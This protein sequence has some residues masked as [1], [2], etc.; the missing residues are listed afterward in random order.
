MKSLLLEQIEGSWLLVSMT[1]K[2]DE[3]KEVDLYG[4]SPLGILTYDENG[5]MNA[6]MGY[7]NR[8][9]FRHQSLGE[10]SMDEITNAYKTY[11]AYYG[12][13]YE[14]EPGMI[15]HQVEGCLF[16]NWQGKEEIRYARIEDGL[17]VISTPPTLFGNGEIVIKAVWRRT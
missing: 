9:N 1:Y 17:L 14:K 6:Q 8:Q 7:S 3:G 4:K 5:Y 12:K 15:I 11:M 16:P 10:G 13:Y 2:D